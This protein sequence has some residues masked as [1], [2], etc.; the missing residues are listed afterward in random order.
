MAAEITIR[1]GKL[2]AKFR[3]REYSFKACSHNGRRRN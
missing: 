2:L 1:E 3:H